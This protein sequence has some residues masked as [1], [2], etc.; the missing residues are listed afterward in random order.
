MS[1]FALFSIRDRWRY[2]LWLYNH[3]S[4]TFTTVL[5]PFGCELVL[6]VLLGLVI[7][8]RAWVIE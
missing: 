6:S 5:L 1:V 2:M 3:I 7:L 8:A 4:M